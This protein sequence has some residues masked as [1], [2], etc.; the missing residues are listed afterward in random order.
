M[1]RPPATTTAGGSP[2]IHLSPTRASGPGRR[3]P[4]RLGEP[5]AH[6]ED[7]LDVPGADLAADVLDVRIDRTLVRLERHSAHG[8]QQLR[9]R[10]HAPRLAGHRGGELELRPGEVRGAAA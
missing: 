9:S 10:E 2:A 8:V 6:A 1:A 5:I 4:S 7:G 3:P